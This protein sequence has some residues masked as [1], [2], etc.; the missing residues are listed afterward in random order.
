MLT[1]CAMRHLDCEEF[2]VFLPD[3]GG[4]TIAPDKHRAYKMI[5]NSIS[6]GLGGH[7]HNIVSLALV[8]VGKGE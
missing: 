1:N 3:Y 6:C 8:A 4:S 7:N 2:A 5:P